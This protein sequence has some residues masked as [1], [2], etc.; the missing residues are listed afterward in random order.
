MSKIKFMKT[1]YFFSAG[2]AVI[3]GFLLFMAACKKENSS[4]TPA[5]K[6]LVTIRINDDPIPDLTNVWV[7][8]R[9][10]EVKVDTGSMHHE[11][12]DYDKD[13]DGD[14]DHRSHDS[15]GIWDTV[16]VTPGVYDLLRFRNGIDTVLATGFASK[17]KIHKIRVTLGTNNSISKDSGITKIPLSICDNKPYV[18]V[19]VESQHIDSTS[20]NQ[21]RIKLDF[22]IARSIKLKDGKYCLKPQIKSYSDRSSGKIEGK[23]LPSDALAMPMAYNSFDSSIAKPD[24]EGEFKICGLKPGTYS[25]RFN[26]SNGYK[27]SVITGIVVVPGKE[28]DLH[29]IL[30]KK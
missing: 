22:D 26:P 15:Y 1:K 18:Y 21:I 20:S 25:I 10:V 16:K 30:L 19:K 9:Y 8:V 3:F 23:V 2:F 24:H 6:Q 5:G 17:G 28:V 13:D 4:Q 7:D 29:T 27:D 11:D 14:D 12:H